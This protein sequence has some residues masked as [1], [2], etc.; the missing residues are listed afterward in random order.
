VRVGESYCNP[1]RLPSSSN[2]NPDGMTPISDFL[3][4]PDIPHS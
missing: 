1:Q 2:P 3:L 4:S